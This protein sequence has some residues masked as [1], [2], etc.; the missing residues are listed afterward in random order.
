M[1]HEA[2]PIRPAT[3]GHDVP[4]R[5][6]RSRPRPMAAIVALAGLALLA[7]ACGS[8]PGSQVAQI[9]STTTHQRSYFPAPSAQQDGPV[10]F[11]GCMRAHGVPNFPDPNTSGVFNK[12]AL[13]QVSANNSRYPAAQRACQHLLPT[14]LSSSGAWVRPRRWSFL[15]AYV[16]TASPTSPTPPPTAVY[17]TPPPVGSIRGHHSS[18]PPTRPAGRTGPP[19]S[20]RMPPTMRGPRR[21]GN[22][23]D[24]KLSKHPGDSSR[25]AA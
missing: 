22:E 21:K 8:S 13:G 24:H 9:G 6:T 19:T 17:P 11:S 15:S 18:R 10:A 1:D 12:V 23:P 3:R 2:R 20:P 25:S 7:A 5:P 16:T 4:R 14:R